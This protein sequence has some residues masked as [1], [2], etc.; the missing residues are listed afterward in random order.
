M[1]AEFLFAGMRAQ[2]DEGGRKILLGDNTSGGA[3]MLR[4]I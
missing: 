4:P 1:R 2:W 3:A